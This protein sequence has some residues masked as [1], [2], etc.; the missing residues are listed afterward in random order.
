VE[1]ELIGTAGTIRFL[2]SHHEVQL[3]LLVAH[4][5]NLCLS[6][7][8]K[9]YNSHIISG[10][11]LSLISFRSDDFKNTGILDVN[12]KGLM[13]EIYEKWDIKKGDLANGAVFFLN[14]EVAELLKNSD[15]YDFSKEVLPLYKLKTNVYEAD[16]IHIDIGNPESLARAQTVFLG[17][18]FSFSAFDSN[19]LRWFLRHPIFKLIEEL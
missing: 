1:D 12:E 17:D 19:F 4:G 6:D 13:V 15:F 10:Q 8:A 5:D 3:P 7:M 2:V 11:S 16:G 9:F 18:H 14:Y